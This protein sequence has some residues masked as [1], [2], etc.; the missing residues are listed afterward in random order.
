MTTTLYTRPVDSDGPWQRIGSVANGP[1][2]AP[3]DTANVGWL[4]SGGT[5]SFTF[6]ADAEFRAAFNRWHREGRRRWVDQQRIRQQM[7]HVHRR[8]ARRARRQR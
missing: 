8:A 4:L 7:R 5:I 3:G 1:T 6:H 2:Y